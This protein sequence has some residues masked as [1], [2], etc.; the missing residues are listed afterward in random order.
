LKAKSGLFL[1]VHPTADD[2][3]TTA[4]IFRGAGYWSIRIGSTAVID[5][6]GSDL[7]E[8]GDS[9]IAIA[10]EKEGCGGVWLSP[11]SFGLMPTA[12]T[13]GT[14][15]FELDLPKDTTPGKYAVCFC[16]NV[17]LGSG[18]L[19][20]FT[21]GD[22]F[23]LEKNVTCDYE[24]PAGTLLVTR[25]VDTGKNFVLDPEAASAGDVSIE[26]TGVDLDW[27]KDRIMIAN[28]QDTCGAAAPSDHAMVPDLAISEADVLEAEVEEPLPP[29]DVEYQEFTDRYCRDNNLEGNVETKLIKSNLC[30]DKCSAD[31]NAPFCDGYYQGFDTAES[32]ALCLPEVECKSLCALL[33]GACSG[34]DMHH[35]YP[36]CFLNGPGC[37]GQ[38]SASP[39]GLGL[40]YDMSYSFLL[41]ETPSSRR[42]HTAV[43]WANSKRGM[44]VMLPGVS[45][46][47]NLRFKDVTFTSPGTYKVCFCDS[48][49]GECA[50]P[51]DFAVEVGK[52]HVSGIHCLLTVPK[53]R[54]TTCYEQYFNGLSC[55]AK[56][57]AH[58]EPAEV[59]QFPSSYDA[60]SSP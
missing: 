9:S 10:P 44:I 34:V 12:L 7:S 23:D 58:G 49:M 11:A 54:T 59:E 41:K 31:P 37:Q 38:V 51:K 5:I 27:R 35:Q 24:E 47:H 39:G 28:C 33:K 60:F 25:R 53:L 46:E 21:D 2:A 22:Y 55:A 15:T 4:G 50:K 26:I 36:R 42:L 19:P 18:E 52:V 3:S 40:G 8:F 45:T 43:N 57:P 29:V 6:D 1:T 56:L 20:T 30:Y 13:A 14:V 16:A 32:A 17:S 48:E